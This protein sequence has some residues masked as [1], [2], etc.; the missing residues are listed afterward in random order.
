VSAVRGRCALMLRTGWVDRSACPGNSADPLAQDLLAHRDGPGSSC[1]HM[2]L[3]CRL[4]GWCGGAVTVHAVSPFGF[5]AV[6]GWNP[7]NGETACV[8]LGY[9]L[10]CLGSIRR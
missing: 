2:R 1:D 3:S 7:Q 8:A 9:G 5:L 6:Q 4:C 10:G